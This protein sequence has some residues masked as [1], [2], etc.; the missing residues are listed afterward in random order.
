VGISTAIIAQIKQISD[1][2]EGALATLE[3]HVTEYVGANLQPVMANPR[4]AGRV[5][6]GL[7]VNDQSGWIA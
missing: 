1:V 3:Q 6:G 4:R 2:N 7:G 5:D